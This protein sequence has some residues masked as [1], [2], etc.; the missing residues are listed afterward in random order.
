M[1]ALDK[2]PAFKRDLEGSFTRFLDG[3]PQGPQLAGAERVSKIMGATNLVNRS[4]SAAA[5]G[6]AVVG[7][8]TRKR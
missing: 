7:A 6:L 3:L 8:W 4:R 2:L 5:G 1:P